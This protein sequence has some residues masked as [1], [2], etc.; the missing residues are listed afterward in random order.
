VGSLPSIWLIEEIDSS[1]AP[2][3]W[4]M[5]V[6]EAGQAVA[7]NALRSASRGLYLSPEFCDNKPKD[8]LICA[9]LQAED[10]NTYGDRAG[11][12]GVCTG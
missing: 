12:V 5:T 3:E 7:L 4:K 10:L 2:S 9:G 11:G 1:V 8:L 6:G